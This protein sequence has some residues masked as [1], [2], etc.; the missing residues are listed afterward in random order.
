MAQAEVNDTINA[1]VDKVWELAADF[2]GIDRLMDGIDS[3]EARGEGVGMERIIRND[4]MD[5]I[6]VERLESCDEDAHT[7]SYSITDETT[8]QMPFS[9]YL[10]TV[11]LAAASEDRTDVNWRGEFEAKGVPEDKA[12]R[13]ARAIYGA[14][15]GA[16]KNELE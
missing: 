15:I 12:I 7:F 14:M 13:F 9:D 10:A 2:A 3:C 11:K 1:S 16:M 8:A 4:G 5:G 6:V